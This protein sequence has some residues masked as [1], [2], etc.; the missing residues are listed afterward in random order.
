ML[1][2]NDIAR[3][4]KLHEDEGRAFPQTC[5]IEKRYTKYLQ[6]IV[7]CRTLISSNARVYV[8]HD[9]LMGLYI[10]L[11]IKVP[12]G[13]PTRYLLSNLLHHHDLRI[14]KERPDP[15][16]IA[17]LERIIK[18]MAFELHLRVYQDTGLFEYGDI[19]EYNEIERW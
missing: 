10:V 11:S 18:S 4:I 3:L 14:L 19:K 8:M 17:Q 2:R 5:P 15:R 6:H 1:D 9:F 7:N 13:H 16:H 12:D